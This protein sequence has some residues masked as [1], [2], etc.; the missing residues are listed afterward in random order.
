MIT[1]NNTDD[2]WEYTCISEKIFLMLFL[3]KKI[4]NGNEEQTQILSNAQVIIVKQNDDNIQYP[5]RNLSDGFYVYSQSYRRNGSP[6]G[7]QLIDKDA[8]VLKVYVDGKIEHEEKCTMQLNRVIK[9]SINPKNRTE[10]KI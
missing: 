2:K 5:M 4:T 9:V 7:I 10:E 6:I 1:K 3:E 8:Y